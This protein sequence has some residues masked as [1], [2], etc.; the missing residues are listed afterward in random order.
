M[1]AGYGDRLLSEVRR[2]APRDV[3]IRISASPERKFSTWIGG[4][5][6]TNK[7]ECVGVAQSHSFS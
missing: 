5:V 4:Y 3:K 7:F 6:L 1:D 2:L